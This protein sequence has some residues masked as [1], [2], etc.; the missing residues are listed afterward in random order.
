[1]S[2]SRG[3]YGLGHVFQRGRIW[4][5]KYHHRGKP[6]Y[7]SS[8]S[9][10]RKDAVAL[11]KE[12]IK[13]GPKKPDTLTVAHAK[14]L[15][16]ANYRIQGL[17][18]WERCERSFKKLM[19]VFGPDELL[20]DIDAGR[21]QLYASQRLDDEAARATVVNELAALKR[22]YTLAMEQ[23]LISSRPAFPNFGKLKNA[24][25]EFIEDWECALLLEELPEEAR[26]M[27][28]FTFVTGW[29]WKSEVRPMKWRQIDPDAGV[30]ILEDSKNDDPR[31]YPYTEH[32]EL[33]SVIDSQRAYTNM[34]EQQ[35]GKPIPWVW[36]VEGRP[37]Q[38]TS[39]GFYR[40]WKDA[41]RRTGVLGA[42][43]E[44]KILHDCRRSAV[45][46]YERDGVS[47]E[48]AKELVGH[49]T[50]SMYSRYNITNLRDK[51][52]AVARIAGHRPNTA[53]SGAFGDRL[54]TETANGGTR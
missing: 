20:A 51:K 17:K 25:R 46:R 40:T 41:C 14:E 27:I 23:K 2:E 22:A 37:F 9:H 28:V 18:S 1:M 52:A 21:L 15:V 53:D 44:P 26:G 13:T 54:V 50:D 45:R 24:R 30:A 31:T 8:G 47:R 10:R 29:R 43:G 19:Q 3:Q 32:P 7:E 11:L 42:D 36:H 33:W 4:W 48:V 38:A 49:R 6:I 16:K 34:W 12:R 39:D 35:T 5:V